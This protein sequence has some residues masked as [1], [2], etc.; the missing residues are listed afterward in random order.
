M[1]IG[2]G[3]QCHPLHC[4]SSNSRIHTT[5]DNQCN[6]SVDTRWRMEARA[7]WWSEKAKV[8]ASSFLII[9]KSI[10]LND[11]ISDNWQILDN[12]FQRGGHSPKRNCHLQQL[13]PT[14][15]III[16]FLDNILKEGHRWIYLLLEYD[17]KSHKSPTGISAIPPY[18]STW[19]NATS[20]TITSFYFFDDHTLSHFILIAVSTV[21]FVCLFHDLCV[22]LWIALTML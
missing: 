4:L 19:S 1:G 15:C 7:W 8:S 12:G 9:G 14:I 18:G 5:A 21:L 16:I 10:C 2:G 17:P 6:I 3:E 22:L 20:Q 13:C 11:I